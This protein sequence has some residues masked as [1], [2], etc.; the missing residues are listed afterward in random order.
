MPA[1]DLK[2]T[3]TG[4]SNFVVEGVGNGDGLLVNE[5]GKYS[6][7]VPVTDGPSVIVI[8]ADGSWTAAKQ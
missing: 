8:T 1:S 7:V 5:I 6:G 3:H 4:S 2:F